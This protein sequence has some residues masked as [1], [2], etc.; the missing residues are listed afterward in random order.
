MQKPIVCV[1]CNQPALQTRLTNHLENQYRLL[2]PKTIHLLDDLL[3]KNEV[4]CIIAHPIQDGACQL[5]EFCQ[6]KKQFKITPLIVIC[7]SCN[8]DF[9]S[10]CANNLADDCVGFAE[11]ELIPERVQ[12]AIDRAN[13]QKQILFTDEQAQSFPP[14]VKR[15]LQIIHFGFT[16]IKFAEDVSRQL[17]IS[18]TTLRKEFKQF[19]GTPFTQY[20]IQTK[21][22][23]AAYLAQNDG[24]T[25][26]AIAHRCGFQDEH[27]FYRS[28]KRKMGIPFAEYKSTRTFQQFNQFYN[29]NSKQ[30]HKS[31]SILPQG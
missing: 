27:E 4:A 22:L 21:L 20:L 10:S 31:I 15:A 14:R 5:W 11:I 13:F 28:F 8:L 2:F 25:G 26:K 6:I 7:Y 12:S 3:K 17:G 18:V 30:F 24:L 19:H 29:H 16:K 9:I 1:F 23:Y